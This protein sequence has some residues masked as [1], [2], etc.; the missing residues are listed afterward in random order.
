MLRDARPV[1]VGAGVRRWLSASLAGAL[2]LASAAT[3]AARADDRPAPAPVGADHA[4]KMQQGLAL[5]KERVRPL[6]TTHCVECHGGKSVKGGFDL[7]DRKPLVESGAIEGGGKSSQLYALITHAEEPHMPAKKPKLPEADA[8]V[9]ARWID[10]GAPYDK[11]LVERPAG[12]AAAKAATAAPADEARNHWAFRPLAVTT[13]P[14][15]KNAAWVRTPIDRYILASLEARGLSPNPIA[16]RR[17]LIR[18][19]A[20][21]LVGLPPTP[22]EVEAFVADPRPDAYERLVDRLLDSSAY[23]ER[24]ARH[25]MDLA[26]FA[27][28][29]GYE[30]DYDRP[31]AYP[32]RDFLIKAL[33]DDL[34]YDTF[35]QWQIAGDELAPDNPQAMAATGFLGAGAFPTQ[36]TEAE[37]ESARYNEL[38]DMVS[39]TG[40]AVLGLTVGCARCHDHKYDPVSIDDYYRLAA[41]FT[42]AIRSEI[43]LTLTPGG[44]PQKVQVTSEGYPHTK[45]HADDRGFPHF[46]PKTYVLARGDTAQKKGEAVAGFL[47]ALLGPGA[48]DSD[49]AVK[50]PAGWTRTS[51]RRAALAAWLT[52]PSRGAGHLTARVIVNRLWQHHLGRGIVSTPS[53]FG[54]QG[55]LPTHPEL[56][57]WLAVDLVHHGWTLKRLH[58]Q[59]VTSAV[60]MQTS[61]S[62]EAR[63]R[64]D[65]ENMLLWRFTPR[66]LE[67]EPI[68]DAMLAVSGRLDPTMFG[69]GSLDPNMTRRSVYFFIKRSQLIP[70]MMLFDWPEHL[71]GIGQRSVTTTA[72]QALMFLNSPLGHASAEGLAGRVAG[73]E[74]NAAIAR[75]YALAYSRPPTADEA[76]LAADFLTRQAA[77]YERDGKSDSRRHAL[78]DLCQ[79]LLSMSEFIYIN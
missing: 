24:W 14:H 2:W 40:T 62:D 63:A 50:P 21:D 7:S 9:I 76:R 19:V 78:V 37:F 36:L 72:P 57:D 69:P 43:D 30:Q 39:T 17:V 44:K 11:P 54:L 35:I 12:V 10:L 15:V 70:T 31:H 16:D 67:A 64:L 49:W 71:V 5:F 26:R 68:R 13:P 56:L 20:F 25:W 74:T 4:S 46:Y 38:D 34:P 33:N 28:S 22:E 65:R 55:E 18:R 3:V 42:T 52:D 23:G 53:D 45:H 48:K 6:L 66:R 79:A 47:H 58:R 27:E 32:Y 73:L 61:T 51:F 77:S 8:E 41:T 60:Y 29:H 1:C 59:I 75:A